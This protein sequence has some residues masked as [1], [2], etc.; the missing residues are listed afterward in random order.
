M[1]RDDHFRIGEFSTLTRLSVRMLRYHDQ[2]GVLGPRDIDPVSGYRFYER[3]QLPEAVLVRQLRDVGFSVSAIAALLPLRHDIDSFGRALTVLRDQLVTDAAQAHRRIA[4]L[5]T[6]L[7]TIKESTM[8][9]ITTTTLPAQRV[10]ALRTQIPGYPA[11]GLAWEQIMGEAA[12]Q[13]IPMPPEP[14][15]ATF[16][17]DGYQEG[18]VDLSV[19]LPVSADQPVAAPL[20][21]VQQPEQRVL[22]ATVIGP[23]DGIGPACDALAEHIAASGVTPVGEMFSRYL[24]GPGRTDDPA[25]YV[26]EICIPIAD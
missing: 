15:G 23:Y 19:W 20:V 14:C 26:T 17:N 25:Q 18:D 11:E 13:R 1:T 2:H 22:T 16:H 6:L 7:H 10:A 12:R 9:T 5:D 8:T 24:V 21:A 3:S 4:D